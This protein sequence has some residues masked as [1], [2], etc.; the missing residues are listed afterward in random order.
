M[1]NTVAGKCFCGKLIK[2]MNGL[3]IATAETTIVT[4][5]TTKALVGT[6]FDHR[7]LGGAR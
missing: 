1:T 4:F 7:W 2:L 5:A 6:R 3:G